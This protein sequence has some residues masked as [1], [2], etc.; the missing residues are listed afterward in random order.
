M[1]NP[2]FDDGACAAVAAVDGDDAAVA[3]ALDDAAAA[4]DGD[5]AAVDD[6]PGAV[7]GSRLTEF[8]LL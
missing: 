8:G 2:P 5:D 7:R 1:G 4:V 6:S 3:A